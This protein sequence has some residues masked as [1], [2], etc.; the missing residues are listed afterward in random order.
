MSLPKGSSANFASSTSVSAVG[1]PTIV[2]HWIRAAATKPMQ[3]VH[4]NSMAH[5]C[6]YRQQDLQTCSSSL[7]LT[8]ITSFL[9]IGC[10]TTLAATV[11]GFQKR[12]GSRTAVRCTVSKANLRTHASVCL[13]KC[14]GMRHTRECS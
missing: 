14:Y 10:L 1:M 6:R 8:K 9:R 11:K 12:A 7:I 2:R 13:V 3:M 4:P 5:T